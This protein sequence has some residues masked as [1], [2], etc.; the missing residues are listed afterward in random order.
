MTMTMTNPSC[1]LRG[2]TSESI[3]IFLCL[4]ET[5]SEYVGWPEMPCVDQASLEF[6]APPASAWCC[7]TTAFASQPL[8]GNVMVHYNA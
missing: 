2:S 6:R 3:F 7:P 1:F 8:T 4:F 5:G